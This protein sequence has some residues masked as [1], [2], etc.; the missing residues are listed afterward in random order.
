[1]DTST[2]Y[3][4][5]ASVLNQYKTSNVSL[6]IN[7]HG[8]MVPEHQRP[9]LLSN[10]RPR[11]DN[12]RSHITGIHIMPTYG[13][14]TSGAP[15][16]LP[17]TDPASWHLPGAGGRI[18]REFR[19]LREDTAG[20][21]RDACQQVLRAIRGPGIDAYR[22]QHT[23]T[24]FDFCDD[25]WIQDV[26]MDKEHGIEFT[27]VCKQPEPTRNMTD[28]QRQTWW[29]RC[30]RFRPGTV[31]CVL[32]RMGVIIHF[33]VSGSTV[34][35]PRDAE[36]TLPRDKL[37]FNLTGDRHRSYVRLNLV[38]SSK[39]GDALRWRLRTSRTNCLLDF[40]DT[41][42]ASFKHT[43]EALQRQYQSSHRLISLLNTY[44]PDPQSRPV[45]ERPA[46][47]QLPGFA[48]KLDCLM[49]DGQSFQ[50]DPSHTASSAEVSSF[51][52]LD[53]G[54]ASALL[55]SLSRE[56]AIID[57]RPCTGKTYLARK[58]IKALAHNRDNAGIGPTICI[59]HDDAALDRMVNHL[60]D[61][62]IERIVR[63]GGHS[64]SGRLQSVNLPTANYT[65]MCMQERRAGD[66]MQIFLGKLVRDVEKWLLRLW[67]TETQWQL[68]GDPVV[69]S[70]GSMQDYII[71]ELE[72]S[73]KEYE[74]IR[75]EIPRFHNDARRQVLQEAQVVAVSV[76]ELAK[77]PEVLQMIHS[78]VL[79][80]DD[81]GD[82]LESQTLTAILPSTEHIIL[83][84]NRNQPSPAVQ[85][86]QLHRANPRGIFKP[87]E[88]S[89]FHRLVNGVHHYCPRLSPSILTVQRRTLP[90]IASLTS[91]FGDTGLGGD[92]LDSVPTSPRGG[93]PFVRPR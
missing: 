39:L 69:W 87:S 71:E 37:K 26:A 48:F 54:Q 28:E 9:S 77:S 51:V 53:P 61:D 80:C 93:H 11:H 3:S 12:D 59:F 29:E 68:D 67:N 44:S 20:R 92:T 62:G 81:A 65:G 76:V 52:D 32:D 75:S 24:H 6:S 38:E 88:I 1:M 73:Y 83:I 34:R 78:K 36:W 2:R 21:I 47:T 30:N 90:S 42:L 55:E 31:V 66:Q 46:Y 72:G 86:A 84:G 35:G 82:F 14:I 50:F 79:V 89:L 17:T 56:V 64:D 16:Y 40:P 85:N 23:S 58:I 5:E 13:E 70:R 10:G 19:L 74:E 18:D 33:V 27:F 60:L 45:V 49:R 57:G 8:A 43:L 41:N 4:A 91:R 15:P 63:V 22:R 25:T 7:S